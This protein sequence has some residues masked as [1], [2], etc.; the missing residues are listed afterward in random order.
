[1]LNRLNIPACLNPDVGFW[2]HSGA[3]KKTY[4]NLSELGLRVYYRLRW[5]N[6]LGVAGNWS[7]TVG[8]VVG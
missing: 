5:V 4:Y 6:T 2:L 8:A 7:E 3:N 1:M